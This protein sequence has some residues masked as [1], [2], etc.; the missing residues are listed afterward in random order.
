MTK[1]VVV[2]I[3]VLALVVLAGVVAG[4][5]G[6]ISSDAVAKV[7]KTLILKADFDKRV[8]EFATQYSVTPK[9]EDPEGWA[10]FEGDVLQY[11]ITYELVTQKAVGL[12]IT[13]TDADVQTEIDSIVTSYYGGDK[14]KFNDRSHDQQHDPR[15]AQSRTIENPC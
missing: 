10:Q 9:E 14:E 1:R 12:G 3:L 5:G 15:P 4:C 2:A 11:L 7:G 8:Q 6:S 13:V